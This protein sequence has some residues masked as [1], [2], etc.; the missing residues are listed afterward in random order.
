[1]K[2]TTTNQANLLRQAQEE[3]NSIDD[4]DAKRT[5][6]R[7]ILTKKTS[8]TPQ[9]SSTISDF[10]KMVTEAKSDYDWNSAEISRLDRLTQDYLHKLELDDLDYRERAKVATQLA[11]CR[12]LRRAS[13]DTV[14][15]LE[16]F[17]DF[18][19]S[20]KGKQTMNLMREA[21]GKTR[22][23]EQYMENRIY[24]YKVLEEYG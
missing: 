9:F 1:M 13:K 5:T 4:P 8:N 11:K 22:K 12:Q 23:A 3:L 21:L 24:R 14:E 17:I 10:C 16:P 7:Q 20:D 2:N 18:I 19:E 15:I 6:R